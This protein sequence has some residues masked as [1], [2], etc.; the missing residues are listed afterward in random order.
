MNQEN[1]QKLIDLM[2]TTVIG[3]I[4]VNNYENK[5]GEM[6]KRRINI[7]YSYENL[8]KKDLEVLNEGVKYIPSASGKYTELD[9]NN[10]IAELKQSI[11]SP[12]K[13]RSEAQTNAYLT[14]TENGAV[15]YNYNTQEIYIMGLE[16]D[17]SKKVVEE[18]TKKVVKSKPITIAKNVIR[19]EYLRAGLI[20]TFVVKNIREIKMRG[21][22]LELG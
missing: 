22:E 3:L 16:L 15:K 11:I 1:L 10:A 9:W 7:G 14:L 4:A 17:G 20:R 12:S 6:S 5:D 13:A 2:S 21:E 18:G 8:K 19:S